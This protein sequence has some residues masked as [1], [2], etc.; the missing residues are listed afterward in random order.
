MRRPPS[1][2]GPNYLALLMLWSGTVLLTF[3]LERSGSDAF[4]PYF[5]A[6]NPTVTVALLSIPAMAALLYL[7]RGGQLLIRAPNQRGWIVALLIA[8]ALACPVILVDVAGGFSE[9]INVRLPDSLLFYPTIAL[10][11]ETV[12]HV[13]PLAV[14]LLLLTPLKT[15]ASRE[16]LLWGCIMLSS[17]L[18]PAFQ[19][20]NAS[21]SPV[22]ATIYVG[23]HILV[24]NVVALALFKRFDF[25]TMYFFRLAYYFLWH[26]LWGLLRLR[27]LF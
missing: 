3:I 2:G 14:L 4:A 16:S 1:I 7:E 8:T 24:F 17:L 22:W 10:V 21:G 26:I 13:L 6:W 25:L 12:F 19:V 23:F 11:A 20:V 9:D 5:G 15:T 18:E 27:L